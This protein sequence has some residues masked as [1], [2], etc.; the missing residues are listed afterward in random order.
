[1]QIRDK[2]ELG[3][4]PCNSINKARL[5]E[6]VSTWQQAVTD[7]VLIVANCH[8]MAHTHR[9]EHLQNLEHD[10]SVANVVTAP[11]EQNHF[12]WGCKLVNYSF[13]IS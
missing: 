7:E 10:R 5:K 2:K 13:I 6:K 8:A 11:L 1:M 9:A 12:Y 3:I 4:V